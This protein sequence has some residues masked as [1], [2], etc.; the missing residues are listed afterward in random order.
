MVAEWDYERWQIQVADSW[1]QGSNSAWALHANFVSSY[2][3][4]IPK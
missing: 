3:T 4:V 1:F 2:W